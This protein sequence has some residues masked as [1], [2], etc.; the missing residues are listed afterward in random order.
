MS[1]PAP[2]FSFIVPALNEEKN[3]P[4][5]MEEIASVT[6]QGGV[7]DY[8]V[9]VI[10]DGSTD[11]TAAVVAGLGS[12]YGN[13]TFVRNETRRGVGKSFLAGAAI[14]RK[15]YCLIV[16]G[17]N[18]FD[19][20]FF[21]GAV[22]ALSAGDS[23]FVVTY[24]LNPQLRPRHRRVI[25]FLYINMFNFLFRTDFRYTNGIVIYPAGWIRSVKLLSAGYTFQSEA[26]LKAC[27]EGKRFAY[28]GMNIR[29]RAHGKTK[30][31]S[32]G[33]MAEVLASLAR[34]K[35]ANRR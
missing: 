22:S 35:L 1:R 33:V 15:D 4:A 7:L 26:L 12:H 3:L 25:S 27:H 5:V 29:P 21:P 18:E 24:V 11:E 31:F 6:R 32:F 9:V 13:I 19:L 17:D 34:I 14:A 2:S 20:D 8:E 28:A 10:D 30:V 23:D 16:P